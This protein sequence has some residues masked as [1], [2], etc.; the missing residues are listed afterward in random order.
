MAIIAIALF[1]M[2]IVIELAETTVM[3][4]MIMMSIVMLMVTIRMKLLNV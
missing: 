1:S 3:V 2:L 4:T